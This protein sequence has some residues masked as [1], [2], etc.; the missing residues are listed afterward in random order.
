MKAKAE[1]RS[2]VIRSKRATDYPMGY[3]WFLRDEA[4]PFFLRGEPMDGSADPSE[5]KLGV[6]L[7]MEVPFLAPEDTPSDSTVRPSAWSP[8]RRRPTLG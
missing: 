5:P 8:W 4:D 3:P 1:G 6:R 7:R 2:E